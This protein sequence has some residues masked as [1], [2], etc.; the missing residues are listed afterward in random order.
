M[1]HYLVTPLYNIE[2]ADEL[3]G[4]KI[5]DYY[6]LK[7]EDI[8]VLLKKI[9]SQESVIYKSLPE[10]V[11]SIQNPHG[12]IANRAFSQYSLMKEFVSD[13]VNF[14]YEK[15]NV[16]LLLNFFR[17]S[18]QGNLQFQD[19]YL[20][21]EDKSVGAFPPGDLSLQRLDNVRIYGKK[22]YS[23]E[24]YIIDENIFQQILEIA[25]KISKKTFLFHPINY[26]I[27]TYES[28]NIY[29]RMIWHSVTLESLLLSNDNK[30]NLT[31]RLKMSCN[32]MMKEN[33]TNIIDS[34]Y[35]IRSEIVH[36]GT[37]SDNSKKKVKKC[38]QVHFNDCDEDTDKILLLK[39][40]RLM[41]NISRNII[42][43][44]L[45]ISI[46]NNINTL[47]E[48]HNFIEQQIQS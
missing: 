24:D 22:S 30:K 8:R 16:N 27:A 39:F 40:D 4:N 45:T 23:D 31:S 17:L 20:F 29:D 21:A 36:A 43:Q 11:I 7:S 3:L 13:S 26:F 12:C 2:I 9:F 37:I 6:I 18:K 32:F 15:Q 44:A 19:S 35:N 38:L 33:I 25:D 46:D 10:L 34:L 42:N 28:T 5:L 14:E 47:K 41:K 48:L 1:K